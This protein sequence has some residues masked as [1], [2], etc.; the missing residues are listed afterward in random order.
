MG[1]SVTPQPHWSLKHQR[2]EPTL[3][4]EGPCPPGTSSAPFGVKQA[5]NGRQ[6]QE[7]AWAAL[8]EYVSFDDWSRGHGKEEAG[9]L[10]GCGGHD[11]TCNVSDSDLLSYFGVF[12][13]HGKGATGSAG[14]VLMP[15]GRRHASTL[16]CS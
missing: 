13:G 15:V 16:S 4:R 1:S 10:A 2:D 8:P 5:I 12:D 7:D 3:Q 14:M 9:P 6:K 11:A